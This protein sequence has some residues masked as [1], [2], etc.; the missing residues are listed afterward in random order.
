MTD[1]RPPK[2]MMVIPCLDEALHIGGLLTRLLPSAERLDARLFV[3]DGGSGD[4]TQDIVAAMALKSD[5][6]VIVHNEKRRQGAGVNLAVERFGKD[7]DYLI[8][9]DAHGAYPDDYCDRLVEE[10]V[11]TGA[12]SVVVSMATIGSGFVQRMVATA[13]NSVIGTGG[14]KHRHLSSGEWVD[15]GHH[16]LLRISAF[17]DIGGYDETF[18]HNE[19]S[20]LD[21]RLRH[22]GYRIWLTNR[23]IMEYYPRSSIAGLY[24]QYFRYGKGRARNIIKHRALPKMRQMVPLLVAP[25]VLLA[26]GASIHWLLSVPFLTWTAVCLGYGAWTALRER[27]PMLVMTG[28]MAMVMHLAWSAGF[29]AETLK[30]ASGRAAT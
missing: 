15:H 11:A 8:R 27:D 5:R 6:I 3:M 22:S 25:A 17:E 14:A 9:I 2:I 4:G 16:A 12:D 23:T 21:Y 28:L 19:D 29:W 13:Q 1:M 20:E 7:A 26:G 10:A 30:T 24:T 18:T